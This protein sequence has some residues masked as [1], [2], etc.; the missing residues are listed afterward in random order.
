MK[1]LLRWMTPL[2]IAF[3]ACALAPEQEAFWAALKSLCGQSF[4][5]RYVEGSARSDEMFAGKRLVMQVR[6]CGEEAIRIP[7]HVG[8]D[9]SRTWVISRTE[10]GLRLKHDHRHEDGSEDEITQYGG[11]TA[12][13]GSATRQDFPA[14]AHTKAMIAAAA[15]NIWWFVVEPGKSFTYGLRREDDGRR[16]RVEFDLSK[17]VDAPPA[18]WGER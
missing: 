11:D 6:K 8:D 2:L 10:S 7:F 3:N 16:F 4:E 18:P 12:S 14:D 13:A 17:T 9:H 5:G 1:H 15:T